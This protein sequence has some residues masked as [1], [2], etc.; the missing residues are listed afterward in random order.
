MVE[1]EREAAH[2][3]VV[4]RKHRY[5]YVSTFVAVLSREFSWLIEEQ[6]NTGGR[7]RDEE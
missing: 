3:G 6:Q 2:S 5:S 7:H 4:R 1:V